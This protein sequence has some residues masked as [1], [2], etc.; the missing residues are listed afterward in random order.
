MLRYILRRIGYM[1]IAMFIIATAT[2]F[3]MK[4][5]PGSPLNDTG[6]LTL[7]QVEM[8]E[9]QYGLNDP[10]PVQYAKY[11]GG[12]LVGDLGTSFQFSNTPVTKIL[13]DR[14]GP[15]IQL[16]TQALIV[17]TLLGVL[18][19]MMAAVFHNGPLDYGSTVLAV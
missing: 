9:G 4:T 2:F 6:D 8:L 17:G 15:S 12:L 14:F 10:V 16:G 1:A 5:L 3:L 13:V 18:L 11:M 7:E 19:G